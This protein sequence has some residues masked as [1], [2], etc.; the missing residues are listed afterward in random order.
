MGVSGLP[1]GTVTFL[2]TDVVGSS[3][4]WESVPS[5]MAAVIERHDSILRGAIDAGGGHVFASG[6]DGV[7][8]VFGRAD[9]AIS[10]AVA[11]Q[12]ALL[13]EPWPPEVP[14]SVRMGLHSG[15]ADERD[16][17][18]FGSAVNR[19]ARVM[20]VAQGGQILVSAL[21]AGVAGRM[22]GVEFV[23]VGERRLRGM[24]EPLEL[25]VVAVDGLE[26]T[27]PALEVVRG[28]L[29][30]PVTEF[31]GDVGGLQQRVSELSSRRLVTLTGPGGVGK[32][33]TAVEIGGMVGDQFPGGVWLVELAAVT[34]GDVVPAVVLSVLGAQPQPGMSTPQSI[35]EW[36]N[37]R[38]TL[39]ILDNGEHLLDAI[40]AL[41]SE[42]VAGSASTTVVVTSREPLGV[43]GEVVR[44]VP[45]LPVEAE[46]VQLFA[47]RAAAVSEG[48]VVD[49][50]NRADVMAV[51]ARLDGIPLAIELAAARVRTL[52]PAEILGR[53][54]DRFRLLRRSGRGGQ[55]RHQTLLATVAWS[56]QLLDDDAA[57]LFRRLSVFGGSFDLAAVEAVCG[58]D[59]IDPLDVLDGLASLVDKSMVIAE[60]ARSGGTRY[61]LLETLWQY[62]EAANDGR[63]DAVALRDRHLAHY[64]AI[65][66]SIRAQQQSPLE[67]VAMTRL[68][69][70]WDNIRVA[71][72][73]AMTTHDDDATDT[74]ISDLVLPAFNSLRWEF[75]EWAT[76][77]VDDW[78]ERDPERSPMLG[79][80][81]AWD[82]IRGDFP[83]IVS[84]IERFGPL[85]DKRSRR[86][87]V[88]WH[89]GQSSQMLAT[90][91]A[92]LA[93]RQLAWV[94]AQIDDGPPDNADAVMWLL[95]N[96]FAVYGLVGRDVS[97]LRSQ[98]RQLAE[99]HDYPSIR[100]I[101]HLTVDGSAVAFPALIGDRTG[102]PA[103]YDPIEGLRHASE[104]A[105]SVG[106]ALID[107][108]IANW[109]VVAI[110]DRGFASDAAWLRSSLDN[111]VQ[112]RL[113]GMIRP[114]V[115]QIPIWFAGIGESHSA[116]VVVGYTDAHPESLQWVPPDRLAT[117]RT[118]ID[119]LPERNA[120]ERIGAAMDFDQL[121]DY[122]LDEFDRIAT[123]SAPTGE[124]TPY[125]S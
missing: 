63:P 36:L 122:L 114:M 73:W 124:Q 108:T 43:A 94:G 117:A 52:S 34:D 2:F 106:A 97:A 38:A 88:A 41:V 42:I 32:T 6:G 116:A 16:G 13:A 79:N 71:L 84:R 3:G 45:S 65:V 44:P 72:D 24:V 21:S 112:D 35:V 8:A 61:R 91:D 10:A 22:P 14:L 113:S 92:D 64:V 60:P 118:L 102:D 107:R 119:D 47:E 9:E 76:R 82:L 30:R 23:S 39:L 4:L 51:C 46:A 90:L 1:S 5:V 99:H 11:A 48:F 28:N 7:A 27:P 111:M 68:G 67:A 75:A 83:A 66:E 74:I 18:F 78:P 87:D 49:D 86:E 19:A 115:G 105:R 125:S 95:F 100:A 80:V 12:L 40:A 121:I 58:F 33:R 20:S 17:D 37:A 110:I 93:D 26:Q 103:D 109:L 77:V 25:C 70:E 96:V 57:C 62:G 29:P 104:L 81:V 69:D 56:V 89:M 123:T 54:D 120:F 59:P 98:T 55:G 31:V 85:R 50:S 53:L 101:A 15:E